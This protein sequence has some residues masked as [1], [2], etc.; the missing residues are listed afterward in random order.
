MVFGIHFSM[1]HLMRWKSPLGMLALAP[2]LFGVSFTSLT[3]GSFEN[4]EN[5][6][7]DLALSKAEARY[8]GLDPFWLKRYGI[9]V[10]K[11]SD[12]LSDADNDGLTLRDEYRYLTDPT[13]ADTDDD[14][15]PDGQEVRKGYSPLGAGRLDMDADGLPDSWEEENGLSSKESNA[16]A[17]P[18]QDGL[19]N[20]QEFAHGTDP[21]EAD[22][23]ADGYADGQEIRNGYDPAAPGVAKPEVKII[24][25][26]LNISA[27]IVLSN[28]VS[29]KVLLEDLTKGVVRYPTTAFAGQDGNMV[30][31]GH[32]SNYSWIKSDYNY[33]FRSIGKLKVGDEIVVRVTQMNGKTFDY[34]YRMTGH[35]IVTP[36]DPEIFANSSKPTL[37][38][39]TCWPL[40]TQLKRYIVT[41]ELVS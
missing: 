12:V 28:S 5:A 13:D 4:S 29:D 2:I 24:I 21:L 6:E 34:T 27:P 16:S 1:Q 37:T 26:A 38:L 41:A 11:E 23:D 18:D 3:Y 30:L 25:K 31:S 14:T 17:D 15:Y 22:T 19:P 36:D 7:I 35:A 20:E 40:G 33:V 10:E 39:V 9:T 32:S 8:F